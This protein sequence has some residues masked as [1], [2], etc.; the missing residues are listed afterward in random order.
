[1]VSVRNWSCDTLSVLS[2]AAYALVKVQ[3]TSV[4]SSWGQISGATNRKPPVVILWQLDD[5]TSN[6]FKKF[7]IILI[8]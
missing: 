2:P 1:M 8:D 3:V 5:S 7:G 6:G 4:G